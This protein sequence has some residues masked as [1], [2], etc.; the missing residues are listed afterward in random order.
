MTGHKSRAL[1]LCCCLFALLPF[2]QSPDA[3]ALTFAP[4]DVIVSLESGPVQWWH[5]NGILERVLP[6]TVLG[7]GEGM[8]FDALGNLYVTRWCNMP[9][10]DGDFADGVEMFNAMGVSQGRFGSG[11]DCGPHA[12]TFDAPGNAYVGHAGCSGAILKLTAAGAPLVAYPVAPDFIGSFWIDL[13]PDGCTMVYTG[14]GPNVKRY[15]VC[16]ATQ[17]TNFNAAPMPGGDTHD[18]R[19]LPDGGVLVSSGEVIARLNASGV[20]VQTYSV[21]EESYWSGLDLVGDGTFWAGNYATSN[22][23]RFH[24][25]TGAMLSSFNTGAPPSNVVGVR[26]KK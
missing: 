24:L 4:G 25:A 1:V 17:L 19:L 22:V 8:A 13:A 9:T 14:W 16:T 3:L 20:L 6:S 7:T 26:V 21:S 11:Y 15:N 12:I 2:K 23:H 10:C 18:I 5:P